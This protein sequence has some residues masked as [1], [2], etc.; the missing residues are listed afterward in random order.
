MSVIEALMI[1][2][3]KEVATADRVAAAIGRISGG[4]LPKDGQHHETALL[5]WISHACAALKRR[6]DQEIESGATD[7]TV[8]KVK[9]MYTFN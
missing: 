1:L 9:K 5:C 8:N 4:Q 7:S 2:Y 6:I 3:A